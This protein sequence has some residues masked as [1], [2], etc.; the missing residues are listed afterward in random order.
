M[1]DDILLGPMG[2]DLDPSNG[3]NPYNP[4]PPMGIM[5]P[6]PLD[7]IVDLMDA[8]YPINPIP[9]VDVTNSEPIV[10]NGI[11]V[12]RHPTYEYNEQGW[13]VVTDIFGEKHY[14]PTMEQA[15]ELTDMLSGLPCTFRPTELSIKL[16]NLLEKSKEIEAGRNNAVA[17]YERAKLNNNVDEMA[18]WAGI[19]NSLERDLRD[20][21]NIPNYSGEPIIAPGIDKSSE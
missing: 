14:Y 10:I 5:P 11:E 20:L 7:D 21:Y 2:N 8:M 1:E 15:Q 6:N 4:L 9:P 18:K 17:E 13:A 16:S 3:L 12:R 19:A